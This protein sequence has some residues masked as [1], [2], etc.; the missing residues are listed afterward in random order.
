MSFFSYQINICTFFT[1]QTVEEVSKSEF[2]KKGKEFTEELGKTA[3]KARE[4]LSSAGES[5]SKS[6][7]MKKVA[8]VSTDFTGKE[9][10]CNCYNNLMYLQQARKLCLNINK[11]TSCLYMYIDKG[12]KLANNYLPST[13]LWHIFMALG[14]NLQQIFICLMFLMH[15]QFVYL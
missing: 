12:I 9:Y 13:T 4:T 5:L 10:H 6:Q 2:G 8:E 3:G 7:P 14:Y 11:H 15:C 1:I